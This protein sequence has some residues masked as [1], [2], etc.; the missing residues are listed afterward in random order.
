MRFYDPAVGPTV[1][2]QPGAV[3]FL[4]LATVAATSGGG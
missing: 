3:D 1:E 2:E 4:V